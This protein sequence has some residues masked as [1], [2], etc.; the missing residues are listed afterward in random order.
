[1]PGKCKSVSYLLQGVYEH[2]L[3]NFT[4]ENEVNQ[5]NRDE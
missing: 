4:F 2:I 5:T 3:S 1:M